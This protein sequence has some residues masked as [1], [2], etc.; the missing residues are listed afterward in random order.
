MK[1]RGAVVEW[2][3]DGTPWRLLGTHTDITE[4]MEAVD[5]KSRFVSRMSHEIRT[6]IC[7]ILHET[8]LLE[9]NSGTAVIADACDQLLSLC[10]DILTVDKLR[11]PQAMSATPRSADVAD[12]FRKALRRHAGEAHKKGVGLD[13]T[14]ESQPPPS[15]PLMIDVSKCNQVVDNLVSNAIK[16]TEAGGTVC[17][18]LRCRP[19]VDPSSAPAYDPS[20]TR[21]RSTGGQEVSEEWQVGIVVRDNGLGIHPDDREFVFDRFSQANSSMQ[22]AGLGLSISKELA[23]LMSGD[24]L[25]RSADVGKGS[26][27]EFTFPACTS[28]MSGVSKAT[29]STSSSA[30]SISAGRRSDADAGGGGE[31]VRS[32]TKTYGKFLF[33]KYIPVSY[34]PGAGDAGKG[35]GEGRGRGRGARVAGSLSH[36]IERTRELA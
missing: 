9:E 23:Q 21:R 12:F 11:R 33:V 36:P 20:A 13:G 16:Y 35:R 7:A 30:R 10:N 3:P 28:A 22:G 5:A 25:L 4:I 18:E 27:F 24:V 1:C 32:L 8:E 34:G 31:Q 14:V 26:T 15:T 29:S 6:P 19:K 17:V 2:L